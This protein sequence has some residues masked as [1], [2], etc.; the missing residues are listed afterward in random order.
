MEHTHPDV[1]EAELAALAT[2]KLPQFGDE[3]VAWVRTNP[4]TKGWLAAYIERYRKG[5]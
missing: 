5:R 1:D 3:D 2:A 4:T